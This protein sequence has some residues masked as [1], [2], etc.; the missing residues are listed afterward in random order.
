MN[1]KYAHAAGR[2]RE[3]IAE[4][5]RVAA[6]ERPSS[7][8]PYIQDHTQLHQFLVNVDNIVRTVF[9]T[10]SAHFI[11]L[12]AALER[13]PER[14]YQVNT[15]V[16]ILGGALSDLEGGF[17]ANQEHLVAAIVFDSALEQ[18]RHLTNSGF[19]DPAAVLCRV[20]VEESLRRLTRQ[21]GL[22]DSGKATALND[23]LR[24]SGRYNKPQWRVIQS[25]LDVGNAAAHGKFSEYDDAAVIRMI[26]DIERFVGQEIGS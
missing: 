25:W 8:G 20:V 15:I 3:L 1:P 16:G 12:S 10:T 26:D 13:H 4:G 5:H 9:G 2:I 14:A 11:H 6:L 22:Q 7:V 24:D 21:S 18:V 23:G 19:K 17:V